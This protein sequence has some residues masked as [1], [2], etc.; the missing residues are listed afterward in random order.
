M[1]DL[2]AFIAECRRLVTEPHAP[3]NVL[4]LMRAVV[5]DPA[6]V[7]LGTPAQGDIKGAL[8]APLFRSSELTVLHVVLRPGTITIPHDHKMWAVIGIYDGEEA[9]TFYRPSPKSGLEV[10]NQRTVRAGEAMLLGEDVIHAIEN[11]LSTETRGLHVYG[12][13]LL[14]A[15]R[16]MW[17]PLEWRP[18][19]YDVPKFYD[20]NRQLARSRRTAAA[21]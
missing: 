10:A 15:E 9:N 14:G 11:P 13:D 7:A 17:D 6:A 1:F 12:G 19:P 4:E 8:D 21:Q 2:E 5:A 20:Y 18:Q 16:T 3:R